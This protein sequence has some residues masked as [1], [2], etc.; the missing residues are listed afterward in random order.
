MVRY[1]AELILNAD[2]NDAE[3]Q[4]H[5]HINVVHC[6]FSVNPGEKSKHSRHSSLL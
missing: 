5:E 6:P 2:L 3:S 4:K 1:Y